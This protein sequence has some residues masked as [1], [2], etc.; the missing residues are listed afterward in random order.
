VYIVAT[1]TEGVSPQPYVLETV[2]K[3]NNRINAKIIASFLWYCNFIY[4]PVLKYEFG[5]KF[6]PDPPDTPILHEY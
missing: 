5:G 1:T 4:N 2:T 6:S 3:M